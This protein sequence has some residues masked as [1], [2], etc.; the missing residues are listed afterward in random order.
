MTTAA[1]RQHD[2]ITHTC[3]TCGH[4]GLERTDYP[5]R[6]C[7]RTHGQADMYEL[8]ESR[9]AKAAKLRADIYDHIAAVWSR[10]LDGVAIDA[11]DV[12]VL[13]M[14]VDEVTRREEAKRI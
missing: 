2:G 5:C 1:S 13:L 3:E 10:Y 4:C 7:I 9:A 11:D 8:D 6:C 12:A 14:I